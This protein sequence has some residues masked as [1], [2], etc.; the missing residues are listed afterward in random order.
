MKAAANR[1]VRTEKSKGIRKAVLVMLAALQRCTSMG[2]AAEKYKSVFTLLTQACS[3]Q[4]TDAAKH[5]LLTDCNQQSFD[6]LYGNVTDNS[7][8]LSNIPENRV[9][10]RKQSPFTA[11]FAAAVE[12]RKSDVIGADPEDLKRGTRNE[13]YSPP[14]MRVV[15]ELMTYYPMWSCVLHSEEGKVH[16]NATVESHFRNLKHSTLNNRKGLRP[17]EIVRKELI[18]IR[19]KLNAGILM[20]K[21]KIVDDDDIC[22][23]EETWP[24]RRKAYYYGNKKLA[25]KRLFELLKSVERYVIS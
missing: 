21:R 1:L 19:A 23:A 7:D 14:A 2:D 3:S 22:D 8:V 4:L 10:I 13:L 20:R 5:S 6:Q 16:S 24:K 12:Q 9:N 15:R 25:K 11:F 18:F 17:G